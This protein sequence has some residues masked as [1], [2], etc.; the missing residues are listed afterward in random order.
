MSFPRLF[1]RALGKLIHG[2]YVEVGPVFKF[3][4]FFQ[5]KEDFVMMTK[6]KTKYLG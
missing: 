3:L 5:E 1:R 4:S 2:V 6:L